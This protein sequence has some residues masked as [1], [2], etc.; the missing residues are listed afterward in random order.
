VSTTQ[1]LILVTPLIIVQLGLIAFALR[2]LLDPDRTVR[3][4]NKAIWAAIIVLGEL[5]GPLA[6]FAIGRQ[7]A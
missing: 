6:Y 5:F 1:L 4:G 3:W 2:D 7:D